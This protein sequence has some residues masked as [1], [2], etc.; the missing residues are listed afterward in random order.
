M[1]LEDILFDEILVLLKNDRVFEA[2]ELSVK[3]FQKKY[4][5]KNFIDST[6]EMKNDIL[7]KKEFSDFILK[8]QK[9]GVSEPIA[10]TERVAFLLMR[11]ERQIAVKNEIY[12]PFGGYVC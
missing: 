1:E 8:L 2:M 3:Y 10:L 5:V 9:N 4:D 11:E 6:V 7:E 12:V